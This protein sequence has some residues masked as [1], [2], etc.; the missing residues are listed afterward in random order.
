MID[1]KKESFLEKLDENP[2]CGSINHYLKTKQTEIKY[3][4]HVFLT[5]YMQN[6]Y[7]IK[8]NVLYYINSI[9][10]EQ[11]RLSNIKNF[12]DVDKIAGFIGETLII[13]GDENL[14][15][16]FQDIE[17]PTITT[18]FN[19]LSR[20]FKNKKDMLAKLTSGD[21][22]ILEIT[23]DSFI[24]FTNEEKNFALFD[25]D[26]LKSPGL[27]YTRLGYEW[28][29]AGNI[30]LYDKTKPQTIILGMDEDSYF[31]CELPG[32]PKTI[33]AAL[34]ALIPASLRSRKDLHRQGEWFFVPETIEVVSNQTYEDVRLTLPK[35]PD[36]ND[37]EVNADMMFIKKNG[38]VLLLNPTVT[39][40]DHE[41]LDLQ[42]WFSFK[43]NTAIRS[44]SEEGVD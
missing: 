4:K 8:N 27:G 14:G 3:G 42:G 13:N 26:K 18:S 16:D 40:W 21:V 22:S 44:F 33:E 24:P 28:H 38:D 43:C 25:S 41:T 35:D 11:N 15:A 7:S 34:K 31:G 36:G 39:H 10:Y 5:D 12:Y 19:C 20:F 2:T 23:S 17:Y 9:D 6:L 1:L 30:L 29:K 32:K 37:H